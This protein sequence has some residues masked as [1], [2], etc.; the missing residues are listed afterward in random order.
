MTKEAATCR[1]EAIVSWTAECKA[2]GI[3]HSDDFSL[4]AVL[5]NPITIRSWTIDGLPNDALSIDNAI[6]LTEARR[7]PLMIDPQGQANRYS[8]PADW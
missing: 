6:I 8:Q 1:D 4:A 5:G 3:P 7:W 2:Q